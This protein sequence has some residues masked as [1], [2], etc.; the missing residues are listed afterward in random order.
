MS[1]LLDLVVALGVLAGAAFFIARRLLRRRALDACTA[2]PGCSHCAAV[3]PTPA[4]TKPLVT[5]G[6]P[7]P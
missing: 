4:G 3:P 6:K 1:P 5:L 7:R 2:S